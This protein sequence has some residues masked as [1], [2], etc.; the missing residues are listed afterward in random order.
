MP[1]RYAAGVRAIAKRPGLQYSQPS[2]NFSPNLSLWMFQKFLLPIPC[3]T[4]A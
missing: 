1:P 2:Q 4:A 3:P